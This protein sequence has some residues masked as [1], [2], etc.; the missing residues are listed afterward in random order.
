MSRIITND[1][2]FQNKIHDLGDILD[3]GNNMYV[4]TSFRPASKGLIAAFGNLKMAVE[5]EKKMVF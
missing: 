1:I 3:E 4:Y 5:I 2:S